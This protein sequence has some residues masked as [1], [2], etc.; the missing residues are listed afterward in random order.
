M[1]EH[2]KCLMCG[3]NDVETRREFHHFLLSGLPNVYV[4][5][6][7]VSYCRSCGDKSVTVPPGLMQALNEAVVLKPG[8]LTGAEIKYLRKDLDMKVVDF[9]ALLGVD[10]MAVSRWESGN[11]K[12]TPAMDLLIR[13]VYATRE[14]GSLELARRVMDSSV[15]REV[16]AEQDYLIP[17]ALSA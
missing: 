7:Q 9:A 5:N 15:K 12:I 6:M 14:G 10:D 3:S 1:S 8:L 16:K 11:E 4:E 2:A 13:L 17:L